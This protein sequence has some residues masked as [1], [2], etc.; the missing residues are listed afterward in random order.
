MGILSSVSYVLHTNDVID[1]VTRS[2]S[3]SNIEMA[4][5]RSFFCRTATVETNIVIVCVIRDIF[6]THSGFGYRLKV[7]QRSKIENV[8]MNFQNPCFLHDSFSLI[9]I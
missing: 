7:R 2:K 6:L 4:I 3:W 1:D 8:F 5:T 9:Q